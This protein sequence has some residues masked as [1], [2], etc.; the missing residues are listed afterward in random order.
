MEEAFK[1]EGFR[2]IKGP[3]G[4]V[5]RGPAN[6]ENLEIEASLPPGF[7]Q[8]LPLV[9]IERRALPRRVPHVEHNGRICF[10]PSTGILIDTDRPGDVIRD[11]IDRARRTIQEGLGGTNEDDFYT[12]FAAYWNA[13]A[14]VISYCQMDDTP[15]IIAMAS[16]SSKERIVADSAEN[17][18][19]IATNLELQVKDFESAYYIPLVARVLP[20]DFDDRLKLSFV[21]RLLRQ[22]MSNEQME[23]L[24]RHR[25]PRAKPLTIFFSFEIDRPNG[26]VAFG[27]KTDA[28][29]ETLS[30]GF[31][32]GKT[33]L[34]VILA[35]NTTASVTRVGV[36]RADATFLRERT[37][38]H[39]DLMERSVLVVGCGSVGGH[40]A[41]L[42]A[43]TGIGKLTLIDGEDMQ[44]EN[45]MRHVL[46]MAYNGQNKAKAMAHWLKRRLPQ[47][48]VT[49]FDTPVGDRLEQDDTLLEKHDAV[50]LATADHAIER[51]LN[52]RFRGAT[53]LFHAWVEA[54]GVGGHVFVDGHD[55][56]GCLSCLFSFDVVH[57]PVLHASLFAPGQKFTRSLGGCAGVF[58]PFGAGDAQRIAVETCRLVAKSFAAGTPGPQ[59]V[60]WLESR[61][62]FQEQ[63]L[64][65][66]DRALALTEGSRTIVT[67][68]GRECGSC[69]RDG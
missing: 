57:G 19:Q 45:A 46:G 44:P 38:N 59:L 53:R 64:K 55:R 35:N 15:R 51:D 26:H 3:D 48:D 21:Q 41:T 37:G 27:V 11:S 40:L 2:P 8:K 65:P 56:P 23:R 62:P 25:P 47:L 42:L 60:T 69:D 28:M 12:E 30:R 24:L 43:D 36:K 50:V 49:Y 7:P 22:R 34:G 33:P 63:G 20:P 1:E 17:V 54:H 58:T 9:R 52:S 67:D 6:I 4:S 10:A 13:S 39:S 61:E 66:S 18:N 68:I 14:H 16:T 5:W 29:L 32:P 31:R